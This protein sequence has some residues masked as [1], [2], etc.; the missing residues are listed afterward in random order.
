[1]YGGIIRIHHVLGVYNSNGV[2]VPLSIP[3]NIAKNPD[4]RV[5]VWRHHSMSVAEIFDEIGP[6]STSRQIWAMSQRLSM[7]IDDLNRKQ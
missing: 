2:A 1:M 7:T 5:I 6:F 3:L 4:K